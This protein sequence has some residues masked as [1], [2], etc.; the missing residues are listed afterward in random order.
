MRLA[1]RTL[2]MVRCNTQAKNNRSKALVKALKK[3][4]RRVLAGAIRAWRE[5]ALEVSMRRSDR[6]CTQVLRAAIVL[7]S[8]TLGESFR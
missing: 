6:C 3:Q 2:N 4:R 8:L 7:S 5:T 1:E